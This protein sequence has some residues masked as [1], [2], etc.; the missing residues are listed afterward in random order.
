MR[1]VRQIL[2]STD[3]PN[4]MDDPA[5]VARMERE[6]AEMDAEIERTNPYGRNCP[7]CGGVIMGTCRCSGPHSI[8]DLRMGHGDRCKNGHRSDPDTMRTIDIA[9]GEILINT[10]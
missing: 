6:K 1:T 3:V 9:T 8:G 4:L 7:K 2:E 10:K 5:F